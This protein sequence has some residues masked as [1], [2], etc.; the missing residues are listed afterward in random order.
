MLAGNTFLGGSLALGLSRAD[1]ALASDG[2]IGF[3]NLQIGLH[4]PFVMA[5]LRAL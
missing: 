4:L 1:L 5:W 3:V 2:L